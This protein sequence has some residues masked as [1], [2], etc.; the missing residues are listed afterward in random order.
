MTA[1]TTRRDAVID[2]LY[3]TLNGIDGVGHHPALCFYD[4]T[5]FFWIIR[6]DVC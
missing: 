5:V 6:K 4:P 1:A 2:L 3:N